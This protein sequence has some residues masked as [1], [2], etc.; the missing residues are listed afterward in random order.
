MLWRCAPLP[1]PEDATI[2][3]PDPL[4]MPTGWL[5]R[6]TRVRKKTGAAWQGRIVGWYSTSQTP[7]GYAVESEVHHGSV[8][9]YPEAALELVP[10][11]L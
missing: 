10:H 11:T 1:P 4:P 9:I 3:A 8:Q 6:G 2:T 5:H 7:R